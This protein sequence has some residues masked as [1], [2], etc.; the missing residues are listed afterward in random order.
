MKDESKGLERNTDIYRRQ[1]RISMF[2]QRLE[3][4]KMH[5]TNKR[6]IK[7]F[8]TWKKDSDAPSPLRQIKLGGKLVVFAG[9]LGKPFD[10]AT[11][12]DIEAVVRTVNSTAISR[13]GDI[14]A[15]NNKNK[16]EP[17]VETKRSNIIILKTF[18]KWLRRND[19]PEEF[20]RVPMPKEKKKELNLSEMLTWKDVVEMSKHTI[21]L[22]DTA[23]IQTLW[24]SGARI[25]ELLTLQVVDVERKY[26]GMGVILHIRRSK[27]LTRAVAIP[28]AGVAVLRYLDEEHPYRN[29]PSKPLFTQ[30]K[31]EDTMITPAA[32]TKVTKLAAMRGGVKKKTNPHA[33]RKA[34]VS[35]Y[36]KQLNDTELKARYGWTLNTQVLRNYIARD[37]DAANMKVMANSGLTDMQIEETLEEPEEQPRK[38]VWCNETSPAG[39]D[40]CVKC[41]RPLNPDVNHMAIERM[42]EIDNYIEIIAKEKGF[43]SADIFSGLVANAIEVV[44]KK[45]K[46]VV[47]A[48]TP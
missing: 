33:F 23:M 13:G 18:Y 16:H 42:R 30:L 10:E 46:K 25:E 1:R 34:S 2:L 7:E 37:V 47:I 19:N 27:T 21:C 29:E 26:N 12:D 17:S 22:R 32:V 6:L 44:E 41:H 4:V 48:N 43:S 35:Y 24:D 5:P 31:G 8:L 15:V 14:Q 11:T 28:K 40:N 20:K 3:R 9:F 38:C 36:S 39:Y 45:K